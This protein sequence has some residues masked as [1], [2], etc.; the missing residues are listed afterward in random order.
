M[1]RTTKK[2][3]CMDLIIARIEELSENPD[4]QDFQESVLAVLKGEAS[5]ALIGDFLMMCALQDE[6]GEQATEDDAEDET[7]PARGRG[8]KAAEEE[9]PPTRG[10]GRRAPEPE[11]EEAE[12]EAPPARGR[13]RKPAAVEEDEPPARG[14]RGRAAPEPEEEAEEEAPPARGRPLTRRR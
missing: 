10:R 9:A 12:D 11:E 6:E 4:N 5:Q 2:P 13:G 7:P 1:A 8:R 14:R 3:D